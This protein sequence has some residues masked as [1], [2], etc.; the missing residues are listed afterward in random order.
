MKLMVSQVEYE[1]TTTV[2]SK[3]K[4]HVFAFSGMMT[5]FTGCTYNYP[6]YSNFVSSYDNYAAEVRPLLCPEGEYGYDPRSVSIAFGEA[7]RS[8]PS[9][10]FLTVQ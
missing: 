10:C 1:I 6:N 5:G 7:V 8:S 4:A 2:L 3:L 9:C